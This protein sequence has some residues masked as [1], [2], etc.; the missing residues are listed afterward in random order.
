MGNPYP[1]LWQDSENVLGRLQGDLTFTDPA[2]Q[3]GGGTGSVTSVAAGDSSITIGGTPTIAPT[4]AVAGLGVTTSKLANL[5]VTQGKLALAAVN[6]AQMDSTGAS[7]GWVP[8]AN[9]SG[10]VVWAASPGV[11]SVTAADTSIV[12]GGTASAPTVRTGTLDVIAT[13]H[14]PVA[15]VALNSQK[16]TGL[17]NGASASD[18]AA[19]G[20]IPT[21]LPPNGSASGDLS[22]SYPGPTVAAIQGVAVSGTPPS[23]NQVLT[24]SDATHAAWAAPSGASPLTT[25]GDVF[26]HSTVDAR[27]PVGTDGQV[28]TADST[29]A[30]GLKWATPSGGGGTK[31][32]PVTF[33]TPDATGNGY[34]FLLATA[35]IREVIPAFLKDVDGFWWGIVR[36][37]Q[38]YSSTPKIIV[39]IAANATSGVT[40]LIVASLVVANAAVYDAALTAETGQNITVPGTAYT[41]ADVTFT[42]STTPTAG[43][44]LLVYVEH[45]GTNGSD[46]LAVDTLMPAAVFQYAA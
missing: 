22:G 46:T 8:V 29:Q 40:T 36:V 1:A 14:P 18:A 39:S 31:Q 35:H 5:A 13:Q 34:A 23:A 4:V 38:D 11:N 33:T 10:A 12:V 32:V 15:A 16:I 30:L 9:G 7:A 27:I 26:G 28:L 2:N 42:L 3:P 21:A 37:P 6:A 19:F 45:N 24:A 44:D 20:Q 25:K 43:A 41:R 17:A